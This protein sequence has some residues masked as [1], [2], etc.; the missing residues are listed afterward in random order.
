[1]VS[2]PS[3]APIR[4]LQWGPG[5]DSASS[6]TAWSYRAVKGAAR[7]PCRK[8]KLP[9]NHLCKTDHT[10]VVWL[11]TS[12]PSLLP[13]PHT[14]SHTYLLENSSYSSD[15][16][17]KLHPFHVVRQEK[18]IPDNECL[19]TEIPVLAQEH[20]AVTECAVQRL[21]LEVTARREKSFCFTVA[22]PLILYR[23]R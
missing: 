11:L 2:V 1:M 22:V 4:Q 17:D 7:H 14:S 12:C 20:Q 6:W 15:K 21:C 23:T 19:P 13:H 5:Q 18:S 16:A 9:L 3:P 8:N 10:E